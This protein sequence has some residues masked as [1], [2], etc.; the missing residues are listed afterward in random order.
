[1]T[2]GL[3]FYQAIHEHAFTAKIIL[4][5]WPTG[6]VWQR[7]VFCGLDSWTELETALNPGSIHLLQHWIHHY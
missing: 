2:A 5:F 3:I 4:E 1:M 7:N 6:D